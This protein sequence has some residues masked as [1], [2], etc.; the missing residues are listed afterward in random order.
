MGSY[1][2]HLGI[3]GPNVNLKFQKDLKTHFKESCDKEFLDILTCTL[4]KVHTSFK[5]GVLQLPIDIDNFAVNLHGFFKLSRA[6][7]EDYSHLEDATEVTAHY[8][9]RHSSVRWLT[10]KYVLV[11]IIEQWPNLKEYFITFIPKQKEFKQTIKET[12]RYKQIVEVFENEL[13]L[14][15]LSFVTFLAHRYENYSLKFQSEEP[16]IHMLHSGMSSLLTDLM[17]NFVNK[18]SL[19]DGS[20]SVQVLKPAHSLVQLNLNKKESLKAKPFIDFGTRAKLL[21]EG[22]ADDEKVK[23]FRSSCLNSY[24]TA[25]TYLQQNLPFNDKIIEYA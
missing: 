25:T 15:Y 21:L 22:I 16:L 2:L 5:Q 9:L 11:R 8:V 24:V 19:F 1:L 14:P 6:R 18:K 17:Q 10:M 13:T 7:H 3:D 12:K 4:Q 23:G 20:D